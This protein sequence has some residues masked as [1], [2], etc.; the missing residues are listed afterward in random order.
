MNKQ[1][2]YLINHP[3]DDMFKKAQRTGFYALIGIILIIAGIYY[4]FW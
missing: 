2:E 3:E 4:I 1:L